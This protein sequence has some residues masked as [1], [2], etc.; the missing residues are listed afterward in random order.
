MLDPKLLRTN[1]DFVVSQLARKGAVFDVE[2]YHNLEHQRKS[3][4]LQTESLQNQR[5]DGSK[6]IGRLMKDGKLEEAEALKDEAVRIGDQ[7]VTIGGEFDQVSRELTQV[8]METPNLPSETVPDGANESDNEIVSVVGS[9]PEFEFTPKDHIELGEIFSGLDFNA[10]ANLA[11]SRFVTMHGVFA[12]LHRA[13]VQYMLDLHVDQ[14]G[15]SETYVPYLVDGAIL[16]GTGQLPKFKNDL[17]RIAP[18]DGG[19]RERYLIPTAEVPLTNLVRDSII[20][21]DRL[22]M[23]MVA[24]TPCFRA[25][26]GS[27][28]RDVR[29]MFRQHQFDKVELVWITRP[30]TSWD[31]LEQLR[32]HAEAVLTG[33]GLHYRVMNLCGA[34][35]GFSAAKTYDLEV[36]LPGQDQF[37]EISS[38][39]ICG[40]FQARRMQA[41][42]RNEAGKPE[43]VHTLNGSGVA[44]GRCL[45]AVVENYQ[46]AD[47]SITVPGVLVPYLKTNLLK[48]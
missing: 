16:E 1:L 27:Y 13:L 39:S 34:D 12:R 7:L 15:Y 11:G 35:L 28:G 45:I 43:L 47:G 21:P 46:N 19:G 4:Q 8:L 36:W 6:A 26:A 18:E 42:F 41:R 9:R 23:Q 25:E 10:A 40:D 37:R 22:P 30:E 29:G 48:P 38:C 24:H 14:H 33:L 2:G 17:F 44:I 5:K 31:A 20:E 3:L 32:G